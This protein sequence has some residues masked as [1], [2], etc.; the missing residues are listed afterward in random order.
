M[1]LSIIRNDLT[2]VKADAIVNTANPDPIIGAGTDRAVYDAAGQDKLLAARKLIGKIA[3]GDAIET[4]AYNLPAKYIIHTVCE[5]YAGQSSLD[6]LADCYHNSLALALELNCKSVAFPLIGTGEYSFPR[7]DALGVATDIIRRFLKERGSSMKVF[8]VVFDRESVDAVSTKIKSYIDDNYV[9]SLKTE[10][11]RYN[12]NMRSECIV[13]PEKTFSTMVME[14]LDA[15]GINDPA[16]YGGKY[17]MY[18]SKQILTNLRNNVDY[19]PS[20]FVCVT[21]CLGLKLT[22]PQTLDLMERAGYTLSR[23]RKAD[24]VVRACIEN[25]VYD[26]F[27]VNEKLEENGCDCLKKLT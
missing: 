23:S 24:V 13:A 5:K 7:A 27:A 25:K 19:H 18:F 8:L 16:L 20:K 21:I 3:P 26:Y 2:K 14:Y 4:S 1:S 6:V 12:R 17:E 11:Y 15:K 22:L 10:E 9:D